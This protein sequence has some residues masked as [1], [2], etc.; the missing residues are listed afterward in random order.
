MKEKLMKMKGMYEKGKNEGVKM[1]SKM[2]NWGK[3]VN[4]N[5]NNPSKDPRSASG[6]MGKGRKK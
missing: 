3:M 6:C 2:A 1:D 5:G 4:S